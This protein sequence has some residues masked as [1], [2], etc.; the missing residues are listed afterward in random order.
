MPRASRCDAPDTWH[1]VM[2]RGLAK[3]TV[4]ETRADARYFQSRL[5][6]A[7]RR[8]QL[9]VHAFSLMTT[10]F[11]LLVRS[12]VGRLSEALRR[13][14]NEYVR[15]FNRTRRR[16]GALFRGRFRS[17]LVDSLVY[18]RVLVRYIDD[19]PVSAGLVKTPADYPYG[20]A[21]AY[22]RSA[23]PPWLER[24]WVESVARDA[25]GSRKYEPRGYAQA[26]GRPLPCGLAHLVERRIAG[27]YPGPDPI[28]DLVRAAPDEVL[29]WMQ[30]K[31]RL[32]DGTK[33]GIPVLH[34]ATIDEAVGR[35]RLVHGAWTIRPSA[36]LVDGWT[37]LRAALLRDLGGLSDRE[38][39][40]RVGCSEV[41][42]GRLRRR[43]RAGVL[44]REY[45]ARAALVADDALRASGLR[46]T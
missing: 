38:I 11:H 6:C 40:A 8:G 4:V 30:R 16:D 21:R 1:H 37:Q 44:Q 24:I 20:S 15:H 23:G 14:Q 36:K 5:A 35:A 9:E 39:A 28:D 34:A 33:P 46:E 25:L 32:A 42:V 10:H 18:R 29:A 26:F 2:N 41:H 43:H 22:M 27:Q 3:R 13:I 7:V 45:A 31:A 12:P 17:K 19:N